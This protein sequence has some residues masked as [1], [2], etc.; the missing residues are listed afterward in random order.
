M[1]LSSSLPSELKLERPDQPTLTVIAPVYN[2]EDT[3]TAF[4]EAMYP[5]LNQTQCDWSICFINDGSTDAT[6]PLILNAA[7]RSHR[8]KVINFAR[9]FGK[10]AA[11]T[12]GVDQSDSDAVIIID[13]DLQDPPDVILDFVAKWREGYDVVYG[14]R[15]SRRD[16]TWL[17]RASAGSFYKLFNRI[18]RTKIPENVGDF[19][20][21][22]RRVVEAV[23]QLPER[24]RFM[25]GLFAWVGFPTASVSFHRAART[26]GST[27]FRFK[28]LWNFALDGLLS[29]STMPLKAWTYLGGLLALAAGG[30]AAFIIVQTLI[31]GIDVPGYASLMVVLLT[32]SAAQLLSLGIIGEYIARLTIEAK[33]R[34]IYILEGTYDRRTLLQK[35]QDTVSDASDEAA[36]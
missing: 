17:K 27:K 2:E 10:E 20:L 3:I 6:L 18:S 31:F 30:Y 4:L 28:N 16:D 26:A 9:N 1:T 24:N 34:P 11:L 36:A 22:D 14:K 23:K 32:A 25:K 29:F 8:I 15:A 7:K 33:Q 5:V 13:V 12:A 19:R 35:P 21:M